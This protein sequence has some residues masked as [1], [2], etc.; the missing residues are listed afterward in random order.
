MDRDADSV[1]TRM[2]ALCNMNR[3]ESSSEHSIV[4]LTITV[5]LNWPDSSDFPGQSGFSLRHNID[6][7]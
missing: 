7:S 2:T 6:M 1:F 5:V 3:F 4:L